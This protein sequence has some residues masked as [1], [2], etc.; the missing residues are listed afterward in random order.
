[1]L[2]LCQCHNQAIQGWSP[3]GSQLCTNSSR[4]STSLLL[5]VLKTLD[6]VVGG[7]VCNTFARYY[8]VSFH[9]FA[10]ISNTS[11]TYLCQK[12]P[13]TSS[14]FFHTKLLHVNK[15]CYMKLW[16]NLLQVNEKQFKL[17][18]TLNLWCYNLL[19]LFSKQL[20][21]IPS[22]ERTFLYCIIPCVPLVPTFF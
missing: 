22:A 15:Q 2:L 11:G 13:F 12:M 14:I 16:T 3:M 4:T 18:H 21:L 5:L 19:P 10:A 6:E 8:Y 1:M 20:C 17:F 7:N 9:A